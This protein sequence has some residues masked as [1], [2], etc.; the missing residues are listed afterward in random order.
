MTE[1]RGVAGTEV[2][3]GCESS[4]D[5][6][7]LSPAKLVILQT[8]A[9]ERFFLVEQP[10]QASAQAFSSGTFCETWRNRPFPDY[11]AALEPLGALAIVSV[12]L[13]IYQLHTEFEMARPVVFLDPTC[14][15]GTLSA[16]ARHCGDSWTILAGDFSERMAYRART[17]L[18]AVFP[19]SEHL[20]LDD[21]ED[22][23][24]VHNAAGASMIGVRHWDAT[25][26]WPLPQLPGLSENGGGMI[27]TA[28]LPWGKNI[29]G[30]D[31]SAAGVVQCL[32]AEFPCALLC[33]IMSESLRQTCL[34]QG[35]LHIL[36][37]VPVGKK[38]VLLFARGSK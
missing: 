11:S 15:T 2:A 20:C 8:T 1:S 27:V 36:H 38:A 34:N 4:T 32:S 12:G 10:A 23:A 9:P 21:G 26:R 31:E 13:R 30:Q 29:R 17:N 24:V 6:T 18:E 16:A 35:W 28:N 3:Q 22:S 14:G 25:Q 7:G 33:L 5:T 37:E 19:D